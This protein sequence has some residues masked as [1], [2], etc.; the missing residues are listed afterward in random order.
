VVALFYKLEKGLST[1]NFRRD[2]EPAQQAFNGTGDGA[3]F[4]TGLLA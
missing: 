3:G 1:G 2:F 4:E